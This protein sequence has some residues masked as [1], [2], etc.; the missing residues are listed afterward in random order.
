M[1]H[2]L[3]VDDEPSICWGFREFL[4]DDGHDVT[5]AASAEEGLTLAEE[6]PPD[7]AVLDVRLPG[8]DGLLAS[9]ECRGRIGAAPIVVITAFGDLETAVRAVREGA[10]DYL[11]QPFDLDQAAEIVGRALEARRESGRPVDERE[12]PSPADGL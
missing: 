7:A 8:M 9:R 1:S 12:H 4:T 3:V 6:R 5:I 2:V 11:P 10:F